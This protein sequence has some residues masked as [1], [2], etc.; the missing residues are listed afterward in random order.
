MQMTTSLRQT[1]VIS[2]I[3]A[4]LA[5]IPALLLFD[6]TVDE[7]VSLIAM[8]RALHHVWDRR[9]KV[10]G[11]LRDALVPGGSAV[12]WEPRWPDDRAS[13]RDPRRRAMAFQNLNEHV[14]GNHFLRPAEIE[15]AMRS[16]GL[17]PR[18]YLFAEGTEAVVVGTR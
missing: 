1:L 17:T 12:I 8:N 13:L 11:I 10:F 3:G 9:D 7:P 2:S 16:V 15:E 14:Q 6:F 4:V 18:T 5:L